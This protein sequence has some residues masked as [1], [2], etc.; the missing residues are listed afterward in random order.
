MMEDA[1]GSDRARVPE[2]RVWEHLR[3]AHGG[4]RGEHQIAEYVAALDLT[5]CA[6]ILAARPDDLGRLAR[7]RD[8]CR[9][10]AGET[11][12][13]EEVIKAWTVQV[14]SGVEGG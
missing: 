9:V 11:R 4:V 7:L 3:R 10:D 13:F 2:D 8:E 12:S 14:L 5:E 1:G 6:R